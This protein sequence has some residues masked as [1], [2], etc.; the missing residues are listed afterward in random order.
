MKIYSLNIK[1]KMKN[2]WFGQAPYGYTIVSD[3][4]NGRKKNTRLIIN[5]KEQ[6]IINMMKK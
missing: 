1:Q 2:E 5:R 6:D 3:M 4:I